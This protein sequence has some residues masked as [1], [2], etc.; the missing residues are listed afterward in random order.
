MGIPRHSAPRSDG[1]APMPLPPVGRQLVE[2]EVFQQIVVAGQGPDPLPGEF[3]TK[4]LHPKMTD[5]DRETNFV[6]NDLELSVR[7]EMEENETLQLAQESAFCRFPG[8]S[9]TT[10]DQK[11]APASEGIPPVI[12][13]EKDTSSFRACEK[14]L[15]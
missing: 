4:A 12:D 1:G 8:I 11:D 2:Q 9:S 6:R 3:Q 10:F 7:P 13:S 5:L 15:S 14:F